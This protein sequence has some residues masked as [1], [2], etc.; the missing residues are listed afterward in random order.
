MSSIY[1]IVMHADDGAT[2]GLEMC[3]DDELDA[4]I[5]ARRI[6]MQECLITDQRPLAVSLGRR[7]CSGEVDWIGG[8]RSAREPTSAADPPAAARRSAP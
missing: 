2:A 5:S 1:V 7:R 4:L 3:F 6:F 8:W